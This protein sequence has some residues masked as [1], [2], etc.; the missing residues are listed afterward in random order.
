MK[1]LSEQKQM[2]S[3]KKQHLT[4]TGSALLSELQNIG[5]MGNSYNEKGH[6]G[7]RNPVRGPDGI[8][9]MPW[10]TLGNAVSAL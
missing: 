9:E 5:H 2:G 3:N 4:P 7:G 1:T 8:P 6:R 10:G